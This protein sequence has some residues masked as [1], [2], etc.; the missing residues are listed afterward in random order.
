MRSNVSRSRELSVSLETTQE[1]EETVRGGAPGRSRTPPSPS[2]ISAGGSRKIPISLDPPSY[3]LGDRWRSGRNTAPRGQRCSSALVGNKRILR[4]QHIFRLQR[5]KQDQRS[6]QTRSQPGLAAE[7]L[8]RRR[9]SW[10]LAL[11]FARRTE[12]NTLSQG[13]TSQLRRV[14]QRHSINQS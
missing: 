10:T 9:T 5:L 1:I 7:S 13:R 6:P 12:N 14:L 11:D 2:I 4:A 8:L 3:I